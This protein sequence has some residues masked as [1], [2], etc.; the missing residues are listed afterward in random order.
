LKDDNYK[1]Q[2]HFFHSFL[3]G[4]KNTN[5]DQ[6]L[7]Y[8]RITADGKRANLSLKRKIAISLWDA[9]LKRAKGTSNEARQI[10]L[11]FPY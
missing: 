2:K 1:T 10:N 4:P 6:A 8:A 5:D 7:L 11:Y 3:G 9:K